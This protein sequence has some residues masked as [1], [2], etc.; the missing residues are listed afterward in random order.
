[1]PAYTRSYII[2]WGAEIEKHIDK[3]LIWDNR[4]KLSWCATTDVHLGDNGWI[5]PVAIS[6]ALQEYYDKSKPISFEKLKKDLSQAQCQEPGWQAPPI[7]QVTLRREY[8]AKRAFADLEKKEVPTA[9]I[10]LICQRTAF[11]VL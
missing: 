10:W 1:M 5:I 4:H 11:L 2:E 8:F 7:I 6:F 3:S 9:V